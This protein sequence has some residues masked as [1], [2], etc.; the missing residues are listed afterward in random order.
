MS[1]VIGIC[2][3]N[4]CSLIAD[5][6]LVVGDYPNIQVVSEKVMKVYKIND[7]VLLGGAGWFLGSEEITSPLDIYPD[8]GSITL[9]T[10]VDSIVK[11]I[12]KRKHKITANRNYLVGGKDEE[13][14]FAMFDIQYDA[15]VHKISVN[16]RIPHPP[17]FNFAVVCCFPPKIEERYNEFFEKVSACVTTSREHREVVTKVAQVISE[18]AQ[19]DDSVNSNVLAVNVF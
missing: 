13:G 4:F 1:V 14:R 3:T 7:Q 9:V 18:I 6:R 8:K 16:P 12:E 17:R 10:A 2:G 19:V 15:V 11:Y 5:G